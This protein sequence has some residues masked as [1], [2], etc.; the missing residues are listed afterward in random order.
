M[1]LP[2]AVVP[3]VLVLLLWCA[4][5]VPAQTSEHSSI[6]AGGSKVRIVRL[7]LVKGEVQMDRA[8]GR[9]MEMAIANLPVVEGSLLE[10]AMGAAEV[11]LED[12]SSLRVGPHSAVDFP[13]LERMP[14]GATVSWV[15]VLRGTAYVSLFKTAAGNDFTLI[16]GGQTL[17][18]PAGSHIRLQMGAGEAKL[19][20]LGGELQIQG[21]SG[22]L[23]VPKKKTVTFKSAAA[24]D[25]TIDNHVTTE[26]LDEW[27]KNSV[28]YHLRLA[29]ISMVN[30]SPVSYGTCDK[31][32]YGS[33]L[34]AGAC[35]RNWDTSTLPL[36]ALNRERE[37]LDR[38]EG[39]LPHFFAGA[40]PPGSARPKRT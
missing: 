7:S 1:D 8:V 38:E 12:N 32:Y 9:G 4:A 33:F 11:E 19:A 22:V 24:G 27:D 34:D 23:Q 13:K 17:E 30:S 31:A 10:T 36:F 39:V 21:Q 5:V 25:P 29:A 35:G 6:S 40:T 26:P 37:V 28:G 3:S 14:G 2:K 15:R 18:L 20:V 16:F